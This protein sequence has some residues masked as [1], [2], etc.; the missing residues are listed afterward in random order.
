ML[1]SRL[2]VVLL[3]VLKESLTPPFIVP[4]FCKPEFGP[5]LFPVVSSYQ[6]KAVPLKHKTRKKIRTNLFIFSLP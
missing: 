2:L 4:E 6:A 3:I 5:V 1:L